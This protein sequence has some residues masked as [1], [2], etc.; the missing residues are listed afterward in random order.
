MSTADGARHIN[1]A[2]LLR[3]AHRAAGRRRDE[4]GRCAG[5]GVSERVSVVCGIEVTGGSVGE[6][7]EGVE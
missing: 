6:E 4:E 1:P 5:L 2:A 7:D 3:R